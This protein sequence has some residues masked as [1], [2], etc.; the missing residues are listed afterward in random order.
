MAYK[1]FYPWQQCTE[2]LLFLSCFEEPKR[3]LKVVQQ[4]LKF[5]VTNLG[6]NITNKP[7]SRIK[8]K[9]LFEI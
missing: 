9:L 6:T 2:P 1:F 7:K 5:S 8:K 4:S 3:S